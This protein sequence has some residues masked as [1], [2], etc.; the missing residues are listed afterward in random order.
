M[1][2]TFGQ[3]IGIDNY[4]IIAYSSKHNENYNNQKFSFIF[5][6]IYCGIKWQCIEYVR[7]WLIIN[8]NVTFEQIDM[9]YM[10]F[11]T[12]KLKFIHITHKHTIPYK[13]IYNNQTNNVLPHIG[14]IIIW[15]KNNNYKTG[16]VAIVSK[17]TNKYIYIGEQ[18]WDDILWNKPF[19]RKIKIQYLNLSTININDYNP[20]QLNILGWINF[21]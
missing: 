4:G 9:A 20:F 14:S 21:A 8:C 11:S 6:N 17:I 5:N 15:D 19:S 2:Q 12:E 16:H 7:R 13:L 1:E 10:M 3:I 18:N